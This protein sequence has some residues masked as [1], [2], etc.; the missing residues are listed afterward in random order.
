MNTEKPLNLI[1]YG[2]DPA[3]ATRIKEAETELEMYPDVEP[4]EPGIWKRLLIVAFALMLLLAI[5]W[6]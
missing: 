3:I 2:A 6:G 1:E 4:A 5:V